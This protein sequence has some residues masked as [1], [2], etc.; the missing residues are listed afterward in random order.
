MEGYLAEWL[1]FK[2]GMKGE[3]HGLGMVRDRG[4][5]VVDKSESE[6]HDGEVG[7]EMW[8]ILE[9]RMRVASMSQSASK[10]GPQGCQS[11]YRRR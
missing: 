10:G 2:V 11:R 5:S 7:G 6:A 4:G 8:D 9:E 1:R 3:H